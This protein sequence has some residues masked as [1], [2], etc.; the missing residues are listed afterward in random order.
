[1]DV[2]SAQVWLGSRRRRELIEIYGADRILFGSDFPM[3]CPID[4]MGRFDANELDDRTR[5]Q[6]LW[7][8]AEVFLG[9]D[10]SE[11]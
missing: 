10:L 1:M 3:A 4:E 11:R 9:Q 5:E 7:R 2:S 8:N 6:I